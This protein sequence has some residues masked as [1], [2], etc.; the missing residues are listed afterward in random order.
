MIIVIKCY[1]AIQ[2]SSIAMTV[3]SYYCKN[4]RDDRDSIILKKEHAT[5][6]RSKSSCLVHIPES[7]NKE[8]AALGN[9]SP[10]K[11]E[12]PTVAPQP[13]DMS[14]HD[15][16]PMTNKDILLRSEE[17]SSSNHGCPVD[18]PL[19]SDITSAEEIVDD[20][21]P[22][23][24]ESSDDEA[25]TSKINNKSPDKNVQ[26]NDSLQ[27]PSKHLTE[28]E[29]KVKSQEE[30]ISTLLGELKEKDRQLKDKDK[31]I[32]NK[33]CKIAELEEANI[34]CHKTLG[35]RNEQIKLLSANSA[36][37]VE[38]KLELKAKL[39]I[40]ENYWK[41]LENQYFRL[42]EMT[43][44]SDE[45]DEIHQE[46]ADKNKEIEELNES[47]NQLSLKNAGLSNKITAFEKEI[48]NL[49]NQPPNKNSQKALKEEKKELEAII[50]RMEN[51]FN[52]INHILH[53]TEPHQPARRDLDFSPIS[54][55][56]LRSEASS[57]HASIADNADGTPDRTTDT[58]P[59]PTP[60]NNPLQRTSGSNGRPPYHIAPRE[61]SKDNF[62]HQNSQRRESRNMDSPPHSPVS[63]ERIHRGS[64][65]PPN[66]HKPRR[67]SSSR[68]IP[69]H[70]HSSR[71]ESS[72]RDRLL[73]HN[74][75][76]AN[77]NTEKEADDIHRKRKNIIILGLPETAS[78]RETM[79]E[80]IHINRRVLGNNYFEK[81]DIHH[82]GRVGEPS[83][84][85]PRP[86]KIELNDIVCKIDVMRNAY[87]LKDHP[88]Y[89]NISIMH[90]LTSNQLKEL[91]R[92][93]QLAK[94]HERE[95]PNNNYRIRG[96]PG[97]WKIEKFPKN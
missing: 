15:D 78:N 59:R 35:L 27:D 50:Q 89:G 20:K 80:F 7:S 56:S 31:T 46:I 49:R 77:Y 1:Q 42:K 5:R 96:K 60:M 11:H 90:D 69:T 87:H 57:Y 68:D 70:H 71:R 47:L 82:I 52:K 34:H 48:T 73:N 33:N 85:K 29:I 79:E 63:S 6:G 2:N 40:K 30:Y 97:Q 17:D 43:S 18:S 76:D 39:Y 44:S 19:G 64:E 84:D 55:T 91:N 75:N 21:D 83:D 95:D 24:S 37:Q 3:E 58:S 62:P 86:V 26:P 53:E 8:L 10:S 4:C 67:T 74:R 41:N 61:K 81:R 13:K 54:D 12:S 94:T 45:D 88:T 28:I 25:E 32:M 14:S 38:E 16:T 92:L 93:K 72:Y 51:K 23:T 36:L 22:I 65:S 9:V 66:R